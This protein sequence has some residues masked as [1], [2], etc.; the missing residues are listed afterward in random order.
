MEEKGI[1]KFQNES[2]NSFKTFSAFFYSYQKNPPVDVRGIFVY[3]I[4]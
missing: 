2:I 3:P 1:G 4:E